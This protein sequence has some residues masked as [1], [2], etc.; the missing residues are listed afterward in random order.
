LYLDCEETGDAEGNPVDLIL[1]GDMDGPVF[2]IHNPSLEISHGP[3]LFIDLGIAAKHLVC[4]LHED[5]TIGHHPLEE[6][7]FQ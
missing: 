2:L 7:A 4:F 5:L 1:D 3:S 6:A